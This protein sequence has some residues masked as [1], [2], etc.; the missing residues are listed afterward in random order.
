MFHSHVL[1]IE[2]KLGSGFTAHIKC[3][4]IAI[5]VKFITFHGN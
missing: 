5:T 3:L 1:N 2:H 4:V